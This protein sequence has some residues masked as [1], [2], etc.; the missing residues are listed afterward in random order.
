MWLQ[1]F[2]DPLHTDGAWPEDTLI[3]V[4]F[5]ESEDQSSSYGN[6]IYTVLLGN[7]IKPGLIIPGRRDHYD[8]LRMIEDNFG[9]CSLAGGDGAA[10][11][12]TGIWK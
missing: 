9:L 11:P 2:L 8:V 10:R 1:G 4:T 7:M 3:V 5:D 6:H 12:I